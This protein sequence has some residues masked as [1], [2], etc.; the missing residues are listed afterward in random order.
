VVLLRVVRGPRDSGRQH[1][2][3]FERIAFGRILLDAELG[4]VEGV[5]LGVVV[6]AQFV[7]PASSRS[8]EVERVAVLDVAEEL[9]LVP[10]GLG[11]CGGHR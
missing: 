4:D 9:V 6:E 1:Q 11:Q 8:S 2:A 5:A 10:E 7:D 3:V